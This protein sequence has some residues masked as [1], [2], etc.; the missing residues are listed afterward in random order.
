[1]FSAPMFQNR[2]TPFSS[3]RNTAWCVALW[4]ARA[5]ASLWSFMLYSHGWVSS[6]RHL[7]RTKLAMTE[8]DPTENLVLP[9]PNIK[10][11]DQWEGADRDTEK[12]LDVRSQSRPRC[13]Y[14]VADKPCQSHWR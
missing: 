11:C 6:R 12:R 3:S 13:P 7:L 10:W 14:D 1:M 8:L 4:T 9:R 5:Q 2:I